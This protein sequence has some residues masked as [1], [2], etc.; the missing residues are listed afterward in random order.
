MCRLTI[1]ALGF[2]LCSLTACKLRLFI[3]YTH[4][5]TV[6]MRCVHSCNLGRVTHRVADGVVIARARLEPRQRRVVQPPR[7]HPA[8]AV[9]GRA[10]HL[11]P[12]VRREAAPVLLRELPRLPAP[13]HHRPPRIARRPLC[14]HRP[15]QAIHT[16]KLR[17]DQAS[18]SVLFRQRA[19]ALSSLIRLCMLCEAQEVHVQSCAPPR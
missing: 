4:Q 1:P 15:V 8:R 13:P 19:S 14:N 7:V 5:I 18:V 6:S 10:A 9:G 3:L 11:Q 2:Y 16:S 17:P 12:R